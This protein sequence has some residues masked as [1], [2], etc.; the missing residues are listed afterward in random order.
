MMWQVDVGVTMDVVPVGGALGAEIRGVSPMNMTDA[1]FAA[2]MDAL[3]AHGVVF[4]PGVGLSSAEHMAFAARMGRLEVF[5]SARVMG[6]TEPGFQ[7]IEDGPDVPIAADNW[8]TD[9]T[10]IDD[11]PRYALLHAELMPERGGDTLWASTRAVF[12]SLSPSMQQFLIGLEARH[13]SQPFID[14]FMEKVA[15]RFP[16]EKMADFATNLHAMFPAVNHP[17]VIEVPE[18]GERALY[19]GGEVM[20][21]IN[22]LEDDESAAIIS[23]LRRRV[24]NPAFQIRWRWTPGDLA[25]WDEWSTNHRN[26]GDYWPQRRI[27]RRT[28]VRGGPPVAASA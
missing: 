14:G 10:W 23:M 1:E 8:H 12:E 27:I 2:F 22:G 11:P 20:T 16:E 26:S 15:G 17:L 4:F 13:E 25:V 21:R 3:H 5:P 9:A 19:L 7:V 24:E 6:G 18:T 28:E